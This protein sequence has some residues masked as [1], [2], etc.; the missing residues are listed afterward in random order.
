M[1]DVVRQ[2]LWLVI[3]AVGLASPVYADNVTVSGNVTFASLDGSSLDHD[4]TA[5]G[6]FTV[7]DGDLTV[8]GSIN[9]NDDTTRDACS[10]NF[11]VS[12]NLTVAS[13]GAIYA[14]NRRGNGGG[15]NIGFN[16]GGN[17]A[18]QP[19]AIVSTGNVGVDRGGDITFTVGGSTLVDAGGIVSSA[20]RGGQ[21]GAI[22][23]NGGGP[24]DIRGLIAAGPSSTLTATKY[25]AAILTGGSSNSTGGAITVR[26]TSHVEP[27]I[28]VGS[29][30]TI[31]SEGDNAGS[32]T[33]IVE[34][35]GVVINGLV[36][37]V[38]SA[39]AGAKITVRSGTIALVD[40]S[41]L[42]GAGTRLGMLRADS[43]NQGAGT[44]SANIFARNSITVL[45]PS[46]GSLYV[47]N[48]NGGK[49]S[50]DPSGTINVIAT[51]GG[52]IAGGNAFAATGSDS[53]DQGG[54][55]NLSSR[56]DLALA[57]ANINASGDFMSGDASRKGGTINVRS[58]SGAVIWVNGSG[59]VRPTGSA[60]GVPAAQQGSINITYCAIFSTAGSSFPTNGA[61]SG[62]FPT[63]TQSCSPAAPSLPPGESHPDCN[64]P[65]I[66][67]NDVYT[68]AEGGTLNVVAPGVLANDV[69]PDGDPI[70]AIL[71]SGPAHASSFTLNANG[72]FTYVHDGGETT[73][74]S[75]TYKANDGSLDSNVA[76]V[77]ITVTPVNDPP[78]ANNDSYNV[79]EGGT[80]NVAAPGVMANDV[81]PDGPTRTAILVT[82]PAHASSFALN[83]DGSFTYV[84]DGSE[85]TSDSF[86]YKVSDG[87]LQSN[88]AT[89]SITIAP[90][91]DAP[92]ANNDTYNVNEGDTLN[93]AAPGV[94][95][96]DTDADGPSIH[97]ILVSGP[98][99]AS[100]FTLNANGSFTYVH[101]G[102][103]TTSDSFTYKANDGSLDSNVATV[104]I[105]VAPVDDAPVANND[106]YSVNEGGTLNVAAPGVL[107]NDTDADGPSIHAV[108]VSGPAHA[109]SFTLNADGSFS[110]VHDGSETTADSF[111]Y[112]ANDGSLDSN[113]ATV[114]I[115]IDPV[116]DPPVANNDSYSV[117]EGDTLNVA[118]PG[119]LANDT[120]ADSP[121]IHAV[122]VSG[123]AHAASFTLNADGS[124]SYVHD[125]S[126]T[127]SDSF[128]Y[129]ANDGSLDSNVATVTITVAPVNDAPVANNDSYSVNEGGT[130]NI[131][132]PGVLVND[133]DIDSPSI[134]AVLVSGPAH[135]ASFTLNADGSFTYVHDG[136][137]TTS[138]AFTYKANDGSLDSN[139]ATVSITINAVNDP[140]VA[141]NDSYGV[142]EGGTLTVTA[143]GVL[144][145]DTDA[146]NNTL[147]AVLVSGPTHAASFA[148]N[149]DGSFTYVHDGSETTGDSLAYRANDGTSLS[150][151]AMVTI[152]VTPVNDAPVAN[153]DSYSVSFHH[154]LNVAAPGVLGNDTDAEGNALSAVLVTGPTQGTLILNA[155][156][157]FSY[158][159][160]GATLGTDSFTYRAQDSLGALSNIATVTISIIN[161]PPVANNDSFNSVGNTELRVGTGPTVTPAV[162]ISGSV[163]ANDIDE[164]GPS[165]L[166]VAS[167][168]PTSFNGGTVSMNPNGSFNYLPPTGFVGTDFFAYSITDGQATAAATVTIVMADRVWYVNATAA[169]TQTG[170]STQPFAA[171]NQA[172]SASFINDYIHLAQGTY[173]TGITLKDGQRLIGS[174]VPLVVGLYALAAATVRPVLQDSITLGS[175]DLVTGLNLA[176]SSLIPGIT[177]A[178]INSGTIAQVDIT[179]GFDALTL[180]MTNG[181]FNI[182]DV[183]ITPSAAGL[184]ILGGNPT[185]NAANLDIVTTT[186]KGI[187]GTAGTLNVSAG[188]NG[189][190][191]A[192]AGGVAV[193]LSG[194]TLNVS[195]LSVSATGGT[196]GINLNNTTGSFSVTGSGTA[197]SGGTIQNTSTRGAQFVNTGSVSLS[198][199][200]FTNTVS[201]NGD[202]ANVCGDTFSGTNLNCNAAIHAASVS[203]LSLSNV[204]VNGSAQIGING[205]NV[206]NLTMNDVQVTNAG[207][208]TLEHGVQFVKV[209]GTG[210]ITNS[211]F[212]NNFYRQFTIQN[213][214]GT[215][216]LAI[217]GSAFNSTGL[218]SGAQGALISGHGTANMAVNVQ[219]STFTNNFGA[220]FFSDGANTAALNVTVGTSTFVND[221]GGGIVVATAG[222]SSLTYDIS[223][224]SS[225]G[226]VSPGISVFKGGGSTGAV[227]GRVVGNTIGISGV[228]GSGCA[229]SCEAIAM[230]ANGS[231]NYIA[232]VT[233]NIVRNF[234]TRAIGSSIS[235]Q[236]VGN[237]SITNNVISEPGPSA[238]NGIFVQSGGLSTDTSSVCADI[239]TNTIT[240][241]YSTR[242]IL[243]RN[244]FPGTTFRLPGYAGA[245]NDVAAVQA[246]LSGQNGG[247]T[248]LATINGNTF[249]G[250]AACVS[251]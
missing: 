8:L 72:S 148:L 145:N 67:V 224:N 204:T 188:A 15:G 165:P 23:I 96:N 6:T 197:G 200:N 221:G 120:D 122:L 249:G 10:M 21:A 33:V 44:Y 250:G 189:S 167:Y 214:S 40:G 100:S 50:K 53:G 42:G 238:S 177:G 74:D 22:A 62:M 48:S 73:T 104:T 202:P 86:T 105:T 245:G 219:S 14:E 130:L 127:T 112:K 159:H 56:D 251:P 94:L 32:G 141:N 184:V 59:D 46:A 101:D 69:D 77:T 123:P 133:T 187:Y 17:V 176:V 213:S 128:T 226:S 26:S 152:T 43:L 186:G 203:G 93:V 2:R 45:G 116:N 220:G 144:A 199:M 107:S 70:T 81:D 233:N 143:P 18:L 168:A 181:T 136:S 132:A 51:A 57:T 12:G 114:S 172:Q 60:S 115:T 150:N 146:E 39:G 75:F 241:A 240:G 210:S 65:P 169:G 134:H 158:T 90:V 243:V 160:T 124:F 182:S 163:L 195:L 106:S 138:D 228:P 88:V 63:V 244:R 222:G 110:Y 232:L 5:N 230:N 162:V 207:N 180:L 208:E 121:S 31:V 242:A 201:A 126:E 71:V 24:M 185:V 149:S 248:V 64:D 98:A 54:T 175:S 198:S 102:S 41:D 19:G 155:D 179:G 87:L 3:F 38:S 129:K 211:T 66:A 190:T 140:P 1:R 58:Y 173:V 227:S 217:T 174:G 35:C 7:N 206:S 119:V 83:P 30:A 9:C 80:L 171:L 234:A 16:V 55:I 27:S 139:V 11:A 109:A 225:S 76:T 118:A 34:G 237:L 85:T 156:G 178:A 28:T 113:V 20:S 91:N 229:V 29:N 247:V 137:E 235:N 68:V 194:M 209:T 61:P 223:N 131:A 164:D 89:A 142:N 25:T 78:V 170:R 151:I 215:M 192:S 84:H 111:T 52:V 212:Q 239:K 166:V 157:S 47:V 236:V 99:H 246:F 92:V 231:G 97:A 196:N 135:A 205:N 4:G 49:T 154:T 37:S 153:N 36:A 161:Q 147:T 13:G 103:E 216:S 193:D 183:T 108:L 82:G 117:N 95:A 79:N 218:S 191:V 125:G